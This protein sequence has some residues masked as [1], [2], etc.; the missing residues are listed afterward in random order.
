ML[1]SLC[2]ATTGVIVISEVC[3][4]LQLC[5]YTLLTLGTHVQQRL[6]QSSYVCF[7]LS[8]C[9]PYSGKPSKCVLPQVPV[10]LARYEDTTKKIKKVFS[11]KILYSEVMAAF[12]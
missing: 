3:S 5:A 8:V 2:I 4:V 12:S 10:P 11:I 7:C 1:Q 6:Q 9:Y